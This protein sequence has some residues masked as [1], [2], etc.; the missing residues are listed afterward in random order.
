MVGEAREDVFGEDVEEVVVVGV[1]FVVGIV[2]GRQSI[3]REEVL[4]SVGEAREEVIWEDAEE[5][6]VVVVV[7]MVDFDLI[8]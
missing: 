8:L 6:V 5:V 2:Q 3:G 1:V 7:M 4:V